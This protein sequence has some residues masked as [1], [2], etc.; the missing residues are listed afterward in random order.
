[1]KKWYAFLLIFILTGITM[2]LTNPGMDKHEKAVGKAI[3]EALS[4]EKARLAEDGN[5]PPMLKALNDD[6]LDMMISPLVHQSV[7]REDYVV[8]SLT[9]LK[10][11]TADHRVGIG[12]FGK[13]FIAP[14]LKTTIKD[15]IQQ[16][17]K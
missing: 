1:M 15:N 10:L 17:L 6:M 11:G 14:Q 13:V 2:W 12:L 8:C 5:L 7:I 9:R 4:E 16:Y 3:T